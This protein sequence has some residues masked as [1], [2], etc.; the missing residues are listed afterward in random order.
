MFVA[1]FVYTLLFMRGIKNTSR[2]S[3]YVVKKKTPKPKQNLAI[4]V[5]LEDLN[6]VL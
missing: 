3:H 6:R 1:G 4:K 5:V 2:F